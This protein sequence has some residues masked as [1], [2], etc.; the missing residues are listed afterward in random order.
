MNPEYIKNSCKYKLKPS[1][2]PQRLKQ[3]DNDKR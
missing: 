3:I 1:A 2:V